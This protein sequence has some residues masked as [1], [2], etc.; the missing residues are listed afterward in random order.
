MPWL[1]CLFMYWVLLTFRGRF[2]NFISLIQF[3]IGPQIILS[4]RD[5]PFSNHF[6]TQIMMSFKSKWIRNQ[7]WVSCFEL[8]TWRGITRFF[9]VHWCQTSFQHYYLIQTFNNFT[10]LSTFK[11]IKTLL[12]TLKKL[13]LYK[14]NNTCIL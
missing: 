4:L 7:N 1:P 14:I 8:L 12:L 9:H 13:K 10:F 11:E 5:L 3:W 2:L 6:L